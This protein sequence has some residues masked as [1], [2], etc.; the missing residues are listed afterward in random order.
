M[1]VSSDKLHDIQKLVLDIIKIERNHSIPGTERHENVGEHSFAV[2]MLCWRI[3]DA[4]NP[5]LSLEKI[6]K[7]ALTHDFCERGLSKDVNTYADKNEKALKKEQEN[8]ALKKLSDEFSDFE[9]L[10]DVLNNYEEFDEEALFVWSIDK[11]QAI[12]LGDIDNWRPYKS[13]G[14]TY[15]E[16]SEKSDY[17][18][19]KCSPYVKDILIAV[20]NN[21]CKT[22]YDNPD[23]EY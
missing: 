10:V 12:I 15:K 11:M 18:I 2:A 4:V 16:F 3:Y 1:K 9:D 13:Y 6:F 17:F 5:P 8:L 19:E 21:A 20:H 7:Y 22:Y 14:V 23:R